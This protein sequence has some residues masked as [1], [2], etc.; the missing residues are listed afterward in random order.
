VGERAGGR[1]RLALRR[2]RACATS[3]GTESVRRA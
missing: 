1:D 2:E 3:W